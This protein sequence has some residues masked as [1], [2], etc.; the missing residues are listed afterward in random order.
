MHQVAALSF[1]AWLVLL[2]VPASGAVPDHPIVPGFERFYTG[3]KAD[4][5]RGGQL[6]LV[7]LNCVS[8]HQADTSLAPRQAPVLDFVATRTRI[9]YLRKFLRDP[10]GVK[11]GTTM[12]SLFA[13]DPARDQKVEALLHFLASSGSLRQERPSL[14]GVATGRDLY[15]RVGC[16]ACHGSR[17]ANGNPDK[18]PAT[19]VPLGDLKAKYSIAGL[20]AFLDNPR[21]IRPSG[22]MPKL[23]AGKEAHDVANYLL[24]G[25]QIDLASGKGATNYSYYEG[26]WDRVPDFSKL[27]PK[28]TGTAVGFDVGVARRH[29]DFALHFEGFLKIEREAVY[30]FLVT[31]DDGSRLYVDGKLVVNNDGIHAPQTEQGSAR[32]FKGV[33]KI[34]VGFMQGG[35]GAELDVQIEAAGF[36]QHNLGDL[37]AVSAAA[38]ER[39]RPVKKEDA[40]DGEPALVEKGRALFASTGCA[41]CHQ[42]SEGKGAIASTLRAP[43]LTKLK[44]E[45]GC[46]SEATGLPRYGLSTTQRAALSASIKKPPP[47][48]KTPVDLIARTLTTFNCYACHVRDKVGGAG[49]VLDKFF[50]TTQPEMGEEGRVPPPLDGVGAKLTPDY[51]RH[52]LDQGVHDRPYMYTR[53]PGFGVANVGHLVEAFAAVDRS[54]PVVSVTFSDPLSRVKA[55]ARHLSGAQA[56]GCIKCHT[57]AG[58]KAEG[59]QGIDMMLMPRRLRHDWFHAYVADPQRFRPGTRMPSAFVDGKSVLPTILDGKATPQIEAIWLYL[60]D[61]KARPPVGLYSKSIPLEPANGAILYR[62]FIEGAGPRAIGVGY[63]ER[64][65]LAFDANG[66]RLAML[67]KGAFID[68]A[69]HWTDRGAGFEGPLGDDVLHL[70][71]GVP[72]AVLSKPDTAWPVASAK[73]IGYRFLGYRLTGDDRPTFRY[74]LGAIEFEDFPN[75]VV[76]GK[77]VS[78]RRVLTAT[79]TKPADTLY[80]RAAVGSKIEA[81]GKGWYRIEGAWQLKVDSEAKV[82]QSGG[83][84]EL[85][86]PV[87]FVAGK[88]RLV[89]EYAW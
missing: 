52:L 41:N 28:A 18:V 3:V 20:A 77:E 85:L 56:L 68:A 86:V 66:L 30:T 2:P 50:Q 21:H 15:H 8:C 48:A 55:Q 13:G 10:S 23:L 32:L 45:G 71:P 25:A 54:E 4:A 46:L 72:F 44:S 6:L 59:V 17:D 19:S 57:F 27:T 58:S 47:P 81:I 51:L 63:P 42:L 64:A 29:D 62:N 14:K 9:G 74:A 26:S 40:L 79:S 7:E 89:L 1:L 80:Y 84:A 83:K 53:M 67:W 61:P 39:K 38:L 73:E 5:A 60:A 65:H 87:R 49:E 75:P 33:H 78:L 70:H 31:S 35:G 82:R 76:T 43:T 12:P 22:R 88:A 69:R 11:P 36:G 24:Q 37:V 16:I 34:T